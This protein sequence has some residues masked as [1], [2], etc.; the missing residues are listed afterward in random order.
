MEEAAKRMQIKAATEEKI[1]SRYMA[2]VTALEE[3]EKKV[4]DELSQL[5]EMQ[6]QAFMAL[7]EML[8]TGKG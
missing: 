4:L 7:E 6:V 8:Y 3:E 2:E 5:K 1:Q